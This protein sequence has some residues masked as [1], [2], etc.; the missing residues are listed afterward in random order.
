VV[1]VADHR[2]FERRLNDGKDLSILF[3]IHPGYK[4]AVVDSVGDFLSP[5][6]PSKTAVYVLVNSAAPKKSNF[7]IYLGRTPVV[8]V[9]LTARFKAVILNAIARSRSWAGSYDQLRQ[10]RPQIEDEAPSFTTYHLQER[11]NQE[12]CCDYLT[13]MNRERL[14]SNYEHHKLMDK[15]EDNFSEFYRL[16]CEGLM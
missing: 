14:L 16:F 12:A 10:L 4:K 5:Y 8:V 13:R 1:F 9:P 11:I 15:V 3:D 2:A 7:S 6:S